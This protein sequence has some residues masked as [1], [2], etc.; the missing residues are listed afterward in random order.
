M[1]C[2]IL[3]L[4]IWVDTVFQSIVLLIKNIYLLKSLIAKSLFFFQVPVCI[5]FKLTIVRRTHAYTTLCCSTERMD[6]S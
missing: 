5:S 1:K 4:F 3:W 2:P 6:L